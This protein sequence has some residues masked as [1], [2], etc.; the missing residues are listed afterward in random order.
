MRVPSDGHRGYF[1]LFATTNTTYCN[2]H[3]YLHL[4]WTY[5]GFSG[6]C[7]RSLIPQLCHRVLE[8][9][10]SLNP[11]I[12]LCSIAAPTHSLTSSG[13]K[14]P[15][16]C[17]CLQPDIIQPSKLCPSDCEEEYLIVVL[18]QNSPV[19]S[20]VKSFSVLFSES[21]IFTFFSLLRVGFPVYFLL[22]FRSS[23]YVLDIIFL[24][25]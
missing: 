19:T 18:K 4:S 22:T 20:E 5:A 8:Y 7:T 17:K 1:Q 21:P 13:W 9:V 12:L 3:S 2:Q 11:G 6:T 14:F 23:L 25:F 16:P 24:Y 10:I 15:F